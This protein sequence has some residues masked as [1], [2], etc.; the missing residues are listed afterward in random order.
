M[1]AAMTRVS[2]CKPLQKRRRA[3]FTHE[4]LLELSVLEME[5]QRLRMEEKKLL[6]RRQHIATR[7]ARLTQRQSDLYAQLKLPAAQP[8]APQV[9]Q[10]KKLSI[11]PA[12]SVRH[13]TWNY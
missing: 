12:G 2:L 7:S 6:E 5:L 4:L 1:N 9:P 13:Q 8:G 3:R 11:K 10:L